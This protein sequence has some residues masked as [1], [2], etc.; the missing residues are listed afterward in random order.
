MATTAKILAFAGSARDGSWNRKLIRIAVEGA[1]E[2]GA[3]VT[4]IELR[5]FPM[6]LYNGDLEAAEGL[7]EHATRLQALFAAHDGL[8]I[9]AP[10]YNS[11]VTPLLKNTIDWVSRP[12]GDAP[13]LKFIRGK[14]A[15]LVSTSTGA[16]GGLR[17]L[18]HL[19]E[20]FGN[21]GVTVIPDQTA[22]PSAASAFD[23]NGRLTDARKEAT[24]KAVGARLVSVTKALAGV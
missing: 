21:I 19:R 16:L 22:V 4:L 24:V 3:E 15:G 9:S 12:N 7:P 13:S 5:D 8:L 1:S 11:S 17:G 18:R 2:A 14:T 10:E 23:E 20:I 6:P